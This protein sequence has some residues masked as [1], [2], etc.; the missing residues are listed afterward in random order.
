VH[1]GRLKPAHF[2]IT[3]KLLLLVEQ[4]DAQQV[5]PGLSAGP[6]MVLG[7]G[8]AGDGDIQFDFPLGAAFIT[9]YPDWLVTTEQ[10]GNRIKISTI[11]TGALVC[12]FGKEGS[13]EGEFQYH[14]ESRHVR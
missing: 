14:R 8:T 6:S 5:V 4:A 7:D 11:R 3:L 9:A 13:G 10:V 12:K 1:A 2:Q